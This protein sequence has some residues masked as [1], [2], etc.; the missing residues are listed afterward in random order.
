MLTNSLPTD[1]GLCRPFDRNLQRSSQ[2]GMLLSLDERPDLE[3]RYERISHPVRRLRDRPAVSVLNGAV[4]ITPSDAVKRHTVVWDGVTAEIVQATKHESVEYRFRAPRH[5]LA[6]YE[7]GVRR[8][9]DTF[10]E[11][12]PRSARR[13]LKGRLT[14][15]PAGH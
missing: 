1:V 13:E 8:E 10:V 12:L 15:V 4:E 7:Q 11:G 5:L 6:V 3:G 9:G 2:A 14:F